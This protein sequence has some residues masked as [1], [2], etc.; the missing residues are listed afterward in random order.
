[1]HPASSCA[2]LDGCVYKKHGVE[3]AEWFNLLTPVRL[4]PI[5]RFSTNLAAYSLLRS[6]TPMFSFAMAATFDL[7]CFSRRKLLA[8]PGKLQLITAH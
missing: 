8:Q 1:M 6:C 4:A 3:Q 2:S 7:V 5:R